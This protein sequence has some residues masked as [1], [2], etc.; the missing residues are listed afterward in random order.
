L[1]D[2]KTTNHQI[3]SATLTIS[4]IYDWQVEA[5]DVLYVNIS[6]D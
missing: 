3:T 1:A 6:P 5:P 2:V 4:N